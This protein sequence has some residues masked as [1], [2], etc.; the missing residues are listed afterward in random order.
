MHLII[1]FGPPAVG[2]M[3][4]GREL[5]DLTGLRLFHNH[6]AIEPVLQLFDF[7][8]PPFA[9]LVRSFRQQVFR[10]VAN[11][12]LPGL[13]YTCLWNLDDDRDRHFIDRLCDLFRARGAQVHF[14][15]LDAT[16]EE[17]LRRNRTPRRI[18]EKPS[19]R[20]VE[21]SERRLLAN[22]SRFRL[23]TD[24]DFP[25][26]ESHIRIDNT[27]LSPREVARRI[28]ERF[29]LVAEAGSEVRPAEEDAHRK[30]GGVGHTMTAHG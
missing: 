27:E 10:E 24:G 13:I 17:R 16:L 7:D 26:P 3:T 14:V 23:N 20:D 4:V 1:L 11:S 19:K 12:D 2:K 21:A 28:A 6:M 5:A 9:R 29:G 30:R 8:S 22:Q 18:A 15:E 25:W